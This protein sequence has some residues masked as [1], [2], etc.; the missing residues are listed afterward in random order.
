MKY[1]LPKWYDLHVH[2][3]QDDVVR[4]YIKA[5][6]DMGCC[7]ALAMPNT[8]PP[9]SRVTGQNTKEFWAIEEYLNTLR[10]HGGD[11]FDDIIVPLYLTH[12]TTPEMIKKG[13]E[14]GFLRACKYYPPHGTTNADFGTAISN[15]IENGV[16][17]AMEENNIVLNI[18]GEEH[19]L[20]AKRYF[21]KDSNA[22]DIFY[23]KYMPIVV[24]KF[25]NLKIVCE[26]ITTKTAVNFVQNANDNVAATI[27]PQHLLFT[28]GNLVKGL[29]YQLYC[30]PLVKFEEDRK[31]LLAAA[32]DKNNSKFFAGTDSAPHAKKVTECGCAAGCFTGLI[33]PQLYA[34]AF[35]LND[36]NIDAFKQFLCTNGPNFYGLPVSTE[37]FILE[38]TQSVAPNLKTDTSEIISLANGMEM[39]ALD[40]TLHLS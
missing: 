39:D 30:L 36:D 27:T 29:K 2:F 24:E 32:T 17:K 31:A 12:E 21:D 20:D 26:H 22:E 35:D 37:T 40:W 8:K 28:V 5:H 16:F 6:I 7:G 33:A 3:R 23:K 9:I 19:G 13:A 10:S 1:T 4:D 18:H 14:S 11:Q 25:P 38:K 34:Q 15:Y